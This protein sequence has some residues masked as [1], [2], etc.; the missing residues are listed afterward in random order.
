MLFAHFYID[1][2]H[3]KMQPKGLVP[4]VRPGR[5]NDEGNINYVQGNGA[6]QTV[7]ECWRIENRLGILNACAPHSQAV[8][9]NSFGELL[10]GCYGSWWLIC[11]DYVG[12]MEICQ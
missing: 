6:R 7:R 9:E 5:V 12:E 11:M 2:S 8:P 10:C 4:I 1:F 3:L